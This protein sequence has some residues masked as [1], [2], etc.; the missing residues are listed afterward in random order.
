[1]LKKPKITIGLPVF[2]GE[3]TIVKTLNSISDQTFTDF[4]VIISDNNST[5][6]TG[7]ICR[8][9]VKKNPNTTY[10]KQ[11]RNVGP[12]NNFKFVLS[13]ADS[14]YF[15]WLAADDWWD[16]SFLEKN[17]S[18]LETDENFV[19]SVSRIKYYNRNTKNNQKGKNISKYK[20]KKFYS[21]EEYDFYEK[22]EDRVSFYL[23]LNAA[24]NIYGL[25]RTEILRKCAQKCF[26]VENFGMDLKTLLYIQR[27]GKINLLSDVL[28]YRSAKGIGSKSSGKNNLTRYNNMRII[29]KI[30]PLLS[31]SFWILRNLGPKIF[32]K[33][34]DYILFI[35]GAATKY[36][37]KQFL[38]K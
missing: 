24:E 3:K 15:I 16:A 32:C 14:K 25:F 12:L 5:D 11:E 9:Y 4:K 35:N 2:N 28:L 19:G 29:G 13:K 30:F 27:F 34:I 31:F 18:A 38:K 37:I 6:R 36:Q 23:R 7:E 22:Y 21:Y 10:V 26:K 1:M 17:V 20:I 8:E 33:N